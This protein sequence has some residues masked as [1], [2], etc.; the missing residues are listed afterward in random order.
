MKKG[1]KKNSVCGDRGVGVVVR[2]SRNKAPLVPI[3]LK[4]EKKVAATNNNLRNLTSI[5]NQI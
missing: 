1:D 5:E 2:V 3:F 4:G